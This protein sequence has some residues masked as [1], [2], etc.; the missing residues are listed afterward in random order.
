VLS[1]SHLFFADSLIR[2]PEDKPAYKDTKRVLECL[3]KA[4]KIADSVM[5]PAISVSLFVDILEKYLWY[6]EKRNEA[7]IIR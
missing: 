7:V 3:Q 4:L 1:L 5:D 2:R 6:Y